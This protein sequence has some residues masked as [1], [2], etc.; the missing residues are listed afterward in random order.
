MLHLQFLKFEQIFPLKLNVDWDN[1]RGKLGSLVM[2]F[3]IK[4][5]T[6]Q[7]R[8]YN[9]CTVSKYPIKNAIHMHV[10]QSPSKYKFNMWNEEANDKEKWE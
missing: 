3:F 1:Y 4:K 2:S 10:Y 7:V 6:W 9:M 5:D 8:K